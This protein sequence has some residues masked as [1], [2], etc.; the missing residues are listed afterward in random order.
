M[1][2]FWSQAQWQFFPA[3]LL[4]HP[5]WANQREPR[6]GVRFSNARNESTIDTAIGGEFGLVRWRPDDQT[7]EGVQ[8]DVMA[9]VFTRFNDRRLLTAADYRV[10]APL[11]YAKGPWQAKLAYEHTSTHLGDEYI[12]VFGRRQA[13]HVRDEI[14]LGLAHLFGQSV[15]IYG[16]RGFPSPPAS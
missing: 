11:T 12:E 5:P 6:S 2:A 3:G 8:F 1:G 14:V 4:W 13:P 9:V 7:Y 16:R 10:G 15:R